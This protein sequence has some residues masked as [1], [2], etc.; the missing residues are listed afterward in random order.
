MFPPLHRRLSSFIAALLVLS[1]AGA[2]QAQDIADIPAYIR[3]NYTRQDYQI[4]MRDGVRLYTI[5][6]SPKD[7]SQKYPFLMTRTP[8]SVAPYNK[9][10]FRGNPV[11]AATSAA[12]SLTVCVASAA[13]SRPSK[14]S[15]SSA[16]GGP[17]ISVISPRGGSREKRA[18]RSLSFPRSIVSKRFVSSRATAAERSP[19]TS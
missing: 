6:Y 2:V 10:T 17:I 18:V 4:P 5:V 11:A 13:R 1:A 3:K 15:G 12:A 8:Y 19:K 7:Q 16:S 9:T 14:S